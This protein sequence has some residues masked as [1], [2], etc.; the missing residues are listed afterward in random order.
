M[1]KKVVALDVGSVRIGVAG[2]DALGITCLLCVVIPMVVAI[3]LFLSKVA[4]TK[5]I[6]L[7]TVRGDEWD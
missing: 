1:V 2:N 5:G 6:D 4:E 3:V 7:N